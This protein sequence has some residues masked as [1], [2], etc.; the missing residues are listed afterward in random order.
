MNCKNVIYIL[1][2]AVALSNVAVAEP[3][4]KP[5]IAYGD[6]NLNYGSL[7]LNW[8]G[9]DIVNNVQNPVNDVKGSWIVPTSLN[10]QYQKKNTYAAF[11]VGIDGDGSNTV[12]QIGTESD[13]I[14]GKASYSAWYEFYPSPSHTISMSVSP[15]DY[16]TAEVNY[17]GGQFILSMTDTNPTTGVSVSYN[18][19][20]TVPNAKRISGEWIVE[21]PSMGSILPLTD[22]GVAYLGLDFT[23]VLNTDYASVDGGNLLSIGSF[24]NYQSITMVSHSMQTK[25]MPSPLLDG[26]TSFTT[27]WYHS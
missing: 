27:T 7:S 8:A 13:C 4:H 22:F 15:G 14:S 21:A 23:K 2:L 19:A 26:G 18:T 24:A 12:E 10:C 3:Q 17:T 20:Q 1:I 9:Y 5:K 16:M 25:A 11:W 6:G